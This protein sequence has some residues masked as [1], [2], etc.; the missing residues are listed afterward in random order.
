MGLFSDIPDTSTTIVNQELE[1]QLLKRRLAALT[2]EAAKNDSILKRSLKRELDL[3]EAGSLEQLL[4]LL[5]HG[6]AVS[7]DLESVTLVLSDLDHGIRHLLI[8]EGAPRKGIQGV[9]FVDSLDGMAPQFT[10]FTNPWLGRY[11]RVDHEFIFPDIKNLGS[12]AL[13]PLLRHDRLVGSLNFGSGSRTR[14]TQLH[15]SDFL[16]RLGAI[17]SFCLENAINR[18]R[19]IRTGLTDVL[20]GW[21]N[22]RYL[23][24]RMHGELA[25]AQR[26]QQPLVC[27]LLDIDH[28][29]RINDAH[30]HLAGDSVL[31]EITRLVASRIRSSDVAA[32]FG[33]DELAVLLPNTDTDEALHLAE[34]IRKTVCHSP[35]K[36]Q[37]GLSIEFTLCIGLAGFIPE[38]SM[39]NFELMRERLIE[40]ADTALYRAKSKGRNRVELYCNE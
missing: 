35:I 16:H 29:K 23:E 5:V 26:N 31:R 18:A 2:T 27:L 21:Y 19:L 12:V 7:Y 24:D 15:A 34:R 28:F 10:A 14:F 6:L 36:V 8:S 38:R 3:L 25:R 1:N 17:A 37:G 20:T 30:G 4:R 9:F 11:K 13:I 33:G 32:R 22:R 39:P 40:Q